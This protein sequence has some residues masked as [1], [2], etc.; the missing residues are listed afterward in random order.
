MAESPVNDDVLPAALLGSGP[1]R[2]SATLDDLFCQLKVISQLRQHERVKTRGDV[3]AVEQASYLQPLV[4][5]WAGE[6]RNHNVYHIGAI[7]E[8]AFTYVSHCLAN[9]VGERALLRRFE[10]QLEA[11]G[12]G[13]LNLRCTYE[14]C[15]VT[16]ARIDVIV[17]KIEA[18]R[19]T[20]RGQLTPGAASPARVERNG[21]GT[22]GALGWAL[23]S[24][25][26]KKRTH[27]KN[28][29]K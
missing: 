16:K 15:S 13:L 20:I 11:T 9:P 3:I 24:S 22:A 2:N 7:V 6:T 14:Q 19:R 27:R 4:R 25:P 17:E 10:R 12:G 8:S 5:W 23:S 21:A 26:P 28:N 29:N 1:L 18:T